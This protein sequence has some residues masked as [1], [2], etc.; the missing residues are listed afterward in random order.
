MNK[1][2]LLLVVGI[3]EEMCF[4]YVELVLRFL[5]FRFDALLRSLDGYFHYF[6][7]HVY[8]VNCTIRVG[9]NEYYLLR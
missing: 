2:N 7:P 8:S 9:R 1:R 6:I 3:L 4:V 5:F